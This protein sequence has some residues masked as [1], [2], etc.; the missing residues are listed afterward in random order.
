MSYLR[1]FSKSEFTAF[2]TSSIQ[3]PDEVIFVSSANIRG[4]VEFKHEG[5]SLIYNK[6]KS[7][8]RIEPCGTPHVI[9]LSFEMKPFTHIFVNDH[10]NTILVAGMH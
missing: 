4:L 8:P 5:R 3:L 7:G 1:R 10:L 9:L 6:N 2:S